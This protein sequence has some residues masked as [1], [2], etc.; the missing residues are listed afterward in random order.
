MNE[1]FLLLL[2]GVFLLAMF[3]I[4][5]YLSRYK[6]YILNEPS[7]IWI[8]PF[9]EAGF[10]ID[11]IEKISHDS[12]EWYY[13][14]KRTCVAFDS[15]IINKDCDYKNFFCA[16]NQPPGNQFGSR[17]EQ[18]KAVWDSYPKKHPLCPII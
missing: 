6:I 1:H 7:K 10:R 14:G 13:D 17:L 3:I 2:S 12:D 5:M 18:A 16:N 11:Q 4:Y 15:S 9:L 8:K